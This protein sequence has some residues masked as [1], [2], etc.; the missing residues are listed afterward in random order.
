M[1]AATVRTGTLR[2]ASWVVRAV[3][4][5]GLV[6]FVVGVWLDGLPWP[7]DLWKAGLVVMAVGSWALTALVGARRKVGPRLGTEFAAGLVCMAV[8]LFSL[9]G[10]TDEGG[11]DLF[12]EIV[13]ALLVLG[14]LA[15]VVAAAVAKRRVEEWRNANN[16]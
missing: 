5:A 6:L 15:L 13:G 2:T 4:A 3:V 10:A 9:F 8:G 11:S 1:E 7:G 16:S 14:G 12:V